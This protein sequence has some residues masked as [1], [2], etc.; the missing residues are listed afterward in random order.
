MA[1]D[2]PHHHDRH[3]AYAALR[4]ANYQRYAL[5]FF[6]AATGLQALATAVGW[7]VYERTNDPLHLGYTGLARAL[8]VVLLALPAGHTAD[9]YERR[10]IIAIS[11]VGFA[12]AAMGL[13]LVSAWHAPIWLVYLLLVFT[14]CCRAFNGPARGSFLPTIVPRG[15]FENA[16]AW[17]S[18]AFQLAAVTGPLLAGAMIWWTKSA[19]PVYAFCAACNLAFAVCVFGI[20]PLVAASA[21]GKYTLASMMAGMGHL[22]RE[23]TILGAIT[24]D[25]FAVLLGGATALLPIFAAD[26]LHV[27]PVG[28]GVLRSS[29]YVGAFAM[30]VCLAHCRPIKRS[31]PALIWSVAGFGVATIVF[32]LSESLWLSLAALF[33]AGAVDNVSV[34]VRHV[35]VQVRTPDHLRGRVGAVNSVFI[36]CSNELGA[37]ESGAVA[38]LFGPVVSVVSGGI[39]T[40]VVAA[41]IAGLFPELRRLGRLREPVADEPA[42]C[43]Q[44]GY[45]PGGLPRSICPECGCP[46]GL[47]GRTATPS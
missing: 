31:G 33:I 13:C 36:E 19:W 26:I 21:T 37:F 41:G 4:N 27:G 1:S 10:T 8:P 47:N 12:L 20:R 23:K 46:F 18:S 25:L 7:E 2:P 16:V 17:S 29:S 24:L 38:R 15:I 43:S 14:G 6:L 22:W 45:D 39:G 42:L 34:V 5:G 9:L 3:D 35:L 40:I 11:Q 30:G 28:L 32:G 44:C